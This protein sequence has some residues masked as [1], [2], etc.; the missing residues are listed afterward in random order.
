MKKIYCKLCD[1]HY[2]EGYEYKIHCY[3]HTKAELIDMLSDAKLSILD[4]ADMRGM[5]V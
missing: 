3:N 5:Y 2:P 1:Y 4:A